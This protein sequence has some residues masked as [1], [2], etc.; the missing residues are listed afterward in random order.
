MT[1][2]FNLW[3][4]KIPYYTGGEIPK[5][6]YYKAAVKTGGGT[7]IICPG[8]AYGFR[9]SH[10]G[11][12]YAEFFNSEGLDA[13]VLDYR[14]A[15]NKYPAALADARRAVRFVRRGA[16]KFGI[17]PDKIAIMGSSAGGH[18]AAHAATYIG[19]LEEEAGDEIDKISCIP[20]GQILCYPVLDC[21][22]HA[23][24][25]RNLLGDNFDE[26]KDGVTP[27]ML[28]TDKTPPAYIWHTTADMTVNVCNTYRYATRLKDLGIPAEIHIYTVGGHGLGLANR[29]APFTDTRPDLP[30]DGCVNAA[31]HV[32]T[33]APL[34]ISW[35]RLFGYY[36]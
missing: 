29:T 34:L 2:I 20:N 36:K 6:T 14:V 12:D 32:K 5:I 23:G 21:E 35:L 3:D 26:L 31:S 25:Y 18:L 7:V 11:H 9:A 17:N 4:G 13:F 10:E 8:G 19:E 24:S 33:W 28:A 27:M 22:G 1:E 30:N 15:P 16:E